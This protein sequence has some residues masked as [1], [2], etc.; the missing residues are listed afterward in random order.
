MSD[1]QLS[2]RVLVDHRD[3]RSVSSY[4]RTY[5]VLAHTLSGSARIV[6]RAALGALR[7][8]DVDRVVK[9]W[10][11]H[12]FEI[13][14]LR[15]VVKGLENVDGGA[16]CVMIGHHTSLLDTPC[17][18]AS[19]PGTV[20]FISKKELRRVPVFGKAMEEAGIVF[21]DRENLGKA[22]AQLDGAKTLL[23]NG[24]ALWVAAE[25]KRS[26]DGR[27]RALK[28]GAFH[29]AIDLQVPLVP[30]WIQGALDVIPPDQWKAQTSQ[31]VTIAYGEPIPTAGK[32]KDDIPALV[33]KVRAAMLDLARACGAPANIDALES[34]R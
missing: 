8:R 6:S 31:T 18:A 7:P 28:K 14:K 15:L 33:E 34:G 2:E 23:Q 13:S 16:P 11:D 19:F 22:I 26:R 24:T 17:I 32:T 10:T 4:W 3:D 30:N 12:I 5:L 1:M 25:G 27:L 21:V 9:R 29:I 20:R